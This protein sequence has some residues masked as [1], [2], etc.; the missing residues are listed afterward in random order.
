MNEAIQ[1]ATRAAIVVSKQ[2]LEDAYTLKSTIN[3]LVR[4]SSGAIMGALFASKLMLLG[5]KDVQV[6]HFKKEGEHSHSSNSCIQINRYDA[7]IIIIDDF[8][9]SGDTINAI[10]E[11]M[12]RNDYIETTTIDYLVVNGINSR[13]QHMRFRPTY[14]VCDE[15][16]YEHYN[17]QGVEA[18]DLF[19]EK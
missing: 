18:K 10:Y 3:I 11:N 4:G 9:G 7:V 5:H 14:L 2:M 1:Y 6:H 17:I 8:I 19:K 16:S 12:M 15:K 13:C